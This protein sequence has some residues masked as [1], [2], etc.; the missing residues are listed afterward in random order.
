MLSQKININVSDRFYQSKMY[1]ILHQE[2]VEIDKLKWIE[3]EKAG[4]DIGRYR[5]VF[6]WTKYYREKWLI[7]FRDS[8]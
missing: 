7:E 5:A 6:L 4:R 2:Q 3:S 8:I 1:R